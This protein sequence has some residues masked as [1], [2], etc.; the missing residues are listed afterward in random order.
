MTMLQQNGFYECSSFFDID[1]Q[2][3]KFKSFFSVVICVYISCLYYR[4]MLK[5]DFQ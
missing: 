1:G 4:T 2:N 3:T 5:Y